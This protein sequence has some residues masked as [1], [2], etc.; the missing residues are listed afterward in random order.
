M[1]WDYKYRGM[2]YFSVYCLADK[3][4]EDVLVMGDYFMYM[5]YPHLFPLLSVRLGVLS[6]GAGVCVPLG[7]AR[8]STVVRFLRKEARHR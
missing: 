4:K 8:V 5:T 2:W 3:T 1:Y 6:E 7:A